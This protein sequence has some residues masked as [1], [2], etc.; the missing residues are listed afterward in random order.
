MA[1]DGALTYVLLL[2]VP[3]YLHFTHLYVKVLI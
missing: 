1:H 3:I 2:G